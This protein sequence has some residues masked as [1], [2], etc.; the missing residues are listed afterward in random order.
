MG[1]VGQVDFLAAPRGLLEIAL[2]VGHAKKKQFQNMLFAYAM[3]RRRGVRWDES[4]IRTLAGYISYYK[5]VEGD[6][7]TR[8]VNHVCGKTGTDIPAAIKAD[9]AV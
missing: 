9:L 5:M 4:D 8:I 3:D 1:K 2:H 6:T 7:I